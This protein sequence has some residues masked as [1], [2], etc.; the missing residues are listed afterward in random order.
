MYCGFYFFGGNTIGARGSS[1]GPHTTLSGYRQHFDVPVSVHDGNFG[2][3]PTSFGNAWVSEI[4]LAVMIAINVANT[5]V[6][7]TTLSIRQDFFDCIVLLFKSI[8]YKDVRNIK[9]FL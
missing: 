6:P 4:E 5:K 9:T 3:F 8:I 1:L 2:F 7:R